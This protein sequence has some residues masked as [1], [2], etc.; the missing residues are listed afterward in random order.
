MWGLI[1]PVL[2]LIL[3][4]SELILPTWKLTSIMEIHET[5]VKTHLT[6]LKLLKTHSD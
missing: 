6:S 2:G 4:T 5:C 3:L 1:Q